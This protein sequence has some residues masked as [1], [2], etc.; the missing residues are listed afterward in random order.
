MDYV[1]TMYGVCM[2]YVWSIFGLEAKKERIFFIT[3]FGRL[4]KYYYLCT[5][6]KSNL[7]PT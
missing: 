5:E 3:E 1:W 7:K 6:F 2:E 4:G